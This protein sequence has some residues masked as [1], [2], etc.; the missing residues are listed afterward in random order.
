MRL[1]CALPAAALALALT[2][3][4]DR[5]D[6]DRI[7]YA[8]VRIPF[9]TIGVWELYGVAGAT[10]HQSFVK[11]EGRPAGFPYTALM[12]TGFGGVLLVSDILG[13]PQAYDLAC[14]V[15]QRYNVRVE[16]DTKENVA[17]CPVCGSTYD[18][19]SNYGNPLS[20]PAINGDHRPYG[21]KRYHVSASSTDY[22]IVTR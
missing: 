4:G 8:P 20:G 15:E 12:E 13:D 22:R 17:R 6:D 21:L 1:L 5:V 9:Q 2:A 16:V 7:P 14:P 11:S 10:A 3:C 18:I 19:Y